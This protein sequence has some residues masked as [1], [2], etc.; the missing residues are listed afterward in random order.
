MSAVFITSTGTDVGKTFVACG[1]IRHIHDQE[2]MV[3]AV[4]P[5][6][7]G[8]LPRKAATSDPGLL[9]TALGRSATMAEIA[10]ISPWRFA[11]PLSPDLAAQ[12]ED[13]QIDFEALV[14]FSRQ[15][16]KAAPGV[17]LI[18]GVG[19][20]MVPLDDRH[21]VLDWMS[22]LAVPVIIVVGNYLGTISHTLTALDVVAG[23]KLEV[24]G[25]VVSDTARTASLEDNARVIRRFAGGPQVQ[26][27]PKL[28]RNSF[29]HPTFV[30]LARRVL[31]GG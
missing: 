20:V 18:E 10:R 1:L 17:L 30:E 9:L 8:F 4:K 29:R 5:V 22:A 11:A 27:L 6:V 3:D 14:A 19:G 15:A 12:K 24:L 26:T 31:S 25:V 2:R 7:S 16:I 21:T 13:R 23:R 28:P